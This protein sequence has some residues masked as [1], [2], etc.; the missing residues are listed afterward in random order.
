MVLVQG[1]S[2]S[3]SRDIVENY[4]HVEAYL[5]LGICLQDTSRP[6][7]LAGGLSPQHVTSPYSSLRVLMTWQLASPTAV[8]HEKESKKEATKPVQFS[9]GKSRTHFHRLLGE[10]PR[11]SHT[12]GEVNETLPFEERSIKTFVDMS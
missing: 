8:T 4:S 3:Y 10:L 11:P 6:W 2:W 1:V 7:L 5:G 12:Q 9:S